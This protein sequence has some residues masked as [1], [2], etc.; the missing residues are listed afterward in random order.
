MEI[1]ACVLDDLY[2][3]KGGPLLYADQNPEG[4][5][6]GLQS[7]MHEEVCVRLYDFGA[8]GRPQ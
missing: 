1:S 8:A 4:G 3:T 2:P 5:E 6:L 7:L